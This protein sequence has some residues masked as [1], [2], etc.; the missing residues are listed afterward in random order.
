MKRWKWRR[1]LLRE[2]QALE[3]HVH[4]P[5]LA[6]ADAAPQIEAASRRPA[7]LRMP[8]FA[9]SALAPSTGAPRCGDQPRAA[10][11]PARRRR[12]QL[13]GVLAK[14]ALLR[15]ARVRSRS[16]ARRPWPVAPSAS[17]Q[18]SSS[19]RSR[20][21]L[22]RLRIRERVHVLHRAAMDHVAHGELGDLAGQRARDIRHG[23][24]LRRHVPRRGRRAD[25]V[26]DRLLQ[27]L[28]ERRRRASA[29]RTA[30]RA[31]RLAIPARRRALR[32]SP[33]SSST[34]A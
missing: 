14:A 13:R 6:A 15:S 2:R 28:V 11:R 32:R 7:R 23:D 31:R 5:G 27:R 10:G 25:R 20:K 22:Q 1:R 33:R 29:A 34:A 3:E 24:D 8:S 17:R 4:Q 30:P 21:M 18:V 16:P 9:S 19:A 26:A 12:L